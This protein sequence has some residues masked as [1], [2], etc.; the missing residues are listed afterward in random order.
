MSEYEA[1]QASERRR[2]M[3]EHGPTSSVS[4]LN[5]YDESRK[6][7]GEPVA[8]PYNSMV[9]PTGAQHNQIPAVASQAAVAGHADA[10]N[11]IFAQL[12]NHALSWFHIKTVIVAGMGF[13]CDSYD[14]FSISLVTPT[15]GRIYYPNSAY[16]CF[17]QK[18]TQSSGCYQILANLGITNGAKVP[19]FNAPYTAEG[20]GWADTYNNEYQGNG[21]PSGDH[22]MWEHIQQHR[23]SGLPVNTGYALTAVA[24]CGTLAGQLLFGYLGD[25]FGRRTV[26]G[27]TLYIM[28]TAAVAQLFS[29]GSSATSVVATLC[30]FRFCLG[31]GVGGDYPLSATLMSEYASK[32]NRGALIAAVFAMQGI[33]YL[34]ASAV[35]IIFSAIWMRAEHTANPDHLW[36]IILAFGAI[37]TAATLYAR[38][39]LPETPRYTMFVNQ[40]AT[41]LVE[42]MNFVLAA[43]RARASG[44][45]V[46]LPSSLAAPVPAHVAPAAPA[47]Q[48]QTRRVSYR[49]FVN[50]YWVTLVGTATCWF[51]LD[52]S[53]YSQNLTQSTVFAS[54]GWLPTAYTMTI[55]REAY[56]TA[57]AQAI[58]ALSSTVPGYWMTV[59]TIEYLGRRNIQFGGFF[60]MTLLMAILAGDFNNLNNTANFVVVYCLTFFFANWGPN[61]TTFILPAEVYP[62]QYRTLGHGFSAACGKAGSIIGTFGFLYMKTDVSLQAALGLLCAVNGAGFFFTFL[63]PETKGRSLEEI[64]DDQVVPAGNA[65]DA[66]GTKNGGDYATEMGAQKTYA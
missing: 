43:E 61:S 65:V 3:E 22:Q 62:T 20:A 38:L 50:K 47:V 13:F 26:F 29:F 31:M 7:D 56:F 24:L 4:N 19:L 32:N 41:Q 25:R 60:M 35:A 10:V 66:K 28:I 1:K 23:P 45:A 55:A 39:T 15:I 63:V 5:A 27:I 11:N 8:S 49:E 54:V 12:D 14:L 16:Q 42:D 44:E 21:I 17:P 30:F 40:N 52:I 58:V 9:S 46:A 18:A 51:L 64:S 34:F 57:R 6:M 48:L 36:R 33:G 53:F 37:P 2:S 59:L